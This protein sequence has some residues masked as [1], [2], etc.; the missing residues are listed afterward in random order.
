MFKKFFNVAAC[1]LAAAGLASCSQSE[2]PV[3]SNPAN[4]MDEDASEWNIEMR[5]PDE[6]KTRAGSTFDEGDDGLWS[7]S[8]DI[9]KIWYAVYYDNALLY[10][11]TTREA[12]QAVKKGDKF[13]LVFRLAKIYD[14]TKVKIFFWAGN[15]AD[16]VT[17]STGLSA[18]NGIV[19][20]FQNRCVSIDQKYLNGNNSS[21]DEYDSFAGYF[22]LP[23]NTRTPSFTL[24]R[25]FAQ[26]HVLSDEAIG[27]GLESVYPSGVVTT[28]GLSRT[29]VSNE[30]KVPTTWF[31]DESI[32]LGDSWHKDEFAFT[33]NTYEFVNTL[34]Q[35]YPYRV[36]FKNRDF[37]CLACMLMFAP[38]G[39][40]VLKGAQNTGNTAVYST[41]NI[42]AKKFGD[43]S[44]PVA[45]TNTVLPEGGIKANNK[46]V[47]HTFE[48]TSENPNPGVI[49]GESGILT[50]TYI[51]EVAVDSDWSGTTEQPAA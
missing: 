3:F 31:Y 2:E 28:M 25:P 45:Y 27:T 51:F 4:P 41:M 40:A 13:N 8:R 23:S 50:N 35:Y 11:C 29:G 49:P 30:M 5:L 6:V 21:I 39:D 17:V 9:N 44:S 1:A 34:S 19:L 42:A 26:I 37:H 24:R 47:I 12:Q 20:N 46:Y 36:T 32:G 43:S 16:K 38:S 15:S 18:S 22:T 10:D 7:F 14:P 33:D 48:H